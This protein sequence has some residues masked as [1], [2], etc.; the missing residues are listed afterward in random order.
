MSARREL[1]GYVSV[2]SGL[3]IV[4]DPYKLDVTVPL[5]TDEADDPYA[6]LERARQLGQ[7]SWNH[8]VALSTH[9]GDGIYPVSRE[10]ERIIV[11][12]DEWLW[13]AEDGKGIR[14]INDLRPVR[15]TG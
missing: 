10:G 1:L 7:D 9:K 3:L 15:R 14:P 5:P 11:A 4:G 13:D 12:L 6:A 8:T 2:D